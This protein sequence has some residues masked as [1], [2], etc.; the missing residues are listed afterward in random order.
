M[1]IIHIVW[2]CRKNLFESFFG[3]T[4]ALRWSTDKYDRPQ[5]VI[6]AAAGNEPA[7]EALKKHIRQVAAAEHAPPSVAEAKNPRL[8]QDEDRGA[9]LTDGAP[10]IELPAR[11]IELPARSLLKKTAD[12]TMTL[13]LAF[14]NTF[15]GAVAIENWPRLPGF[16]D[17]KVPIEQNLTPLA[18][19]GPQ[20]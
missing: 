16:K 15:A 11:T 19:T 17:I 9:K 6:R 12:D 13:C 1:L 14:E 10:T 18:P 4:V 20:T 8:L 2:P 7:I 3:P 5:V